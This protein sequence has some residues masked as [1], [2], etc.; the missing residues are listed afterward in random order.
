MRVAAMSRLPRRNAAA[1]LCCLA[2]ALMCGCATPKTYDYAAFRQSRP[3]SILI[4]PPVNNSTA[5][6]AT[7]SLLSQMTLPLAESGYYVLPVTLVDETFRQNGLGN[8]ADAAAAPT[9]KL[10]EIFGADAALYVTVKQYGTVYAVLNSA[11]VVEADGRLVDLR[12]GALL[13]EG[14]ASASSAEN[15]AYSDAS[16]IGLLVN[17]IIYQ[18]VEQTT[19][20]SHNVAGI[21]SARLLAAG[22]PGGMLYG[23]RSPNF[24]KE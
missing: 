21:A 17:A 19:D 13:W 18:I 5:V 20:A 15:R 11:S 2:A 8:P 12:S 22:T 14:T 16:L 23:P 3:R 4:L 24:Q 9:T 6:E 7:Y 1:A 10:H